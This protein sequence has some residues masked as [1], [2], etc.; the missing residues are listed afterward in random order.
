VAQPSHA[1]LDALRRPSSATSDYTRTSRPELSVEE[2]L[3]IGLH[4]P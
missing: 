3:S 1:P 2:W 4:S